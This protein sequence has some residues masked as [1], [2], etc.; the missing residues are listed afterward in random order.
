[1]HGSNALFYRSVLMADPQAISPGVGLPVAMEDGAL[2]ALADP[3]LDCRVVVLGP[4]GLELTCAMIRQGYVEVTMARPC[5]R[6]RAREA[7]VVLVPQAV[8]AEALYRAAAFA[9][10]A[11][12]PLGTVVIRL[13]AEVSAPHAVQQLKKHG[14]TAVRSRTE[15]A[16]VLL[17]AELPMFGQLACA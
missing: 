7:D 2:L 16:K 13:A 3:G 17:R 9:R 15:G 14:F 8:T 11:L 12:A 10:V 5:E 6:P 1:M 4:G